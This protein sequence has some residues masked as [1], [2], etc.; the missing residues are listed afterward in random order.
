MIFSTRF[1][2]MWNGTPLSPIIPSRGYIREILYLHAYLFYV[3]KDYLYILLE[4]VVQDRAIHPVTFR[5]Q[6]K[7]LIFSLLMISF[8]SQKQK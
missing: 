6:I 7:F 1:N 4:E 2:I 3:W 8:F 5:G